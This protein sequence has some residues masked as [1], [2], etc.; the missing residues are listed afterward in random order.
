MVQVLEDNYFMSNYSY[1]SLGAEEVIVHVVGETT[2]LLEPGNRSLL[3]QLEEDV[4][5]PLVGLLVGHAG[6][7][8]EVH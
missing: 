1:L 2:F 4:V 6:L 7:L 8:Q 5:A 3:H